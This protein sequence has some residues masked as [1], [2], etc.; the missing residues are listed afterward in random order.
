MPNHVSL[1]AAAGLLVRSR[2]I[3]VVGVSGAGKSTLSQNIVA[4]LGLRYVSL[5]RDV[6]WLPGWEVRP[7]DAQRRLHDGFVAEEN[8]VID[9]TTI[10]LMDTR[11]SRA[12]LLI[13]LRVPRRIAL[14]GVLRRVLSSYGQTRPDMAPGCPEQF[15]D[16]EFLN[17]IWTFEKRQCPRLFSAID[18]HAPDLPVVTLTS[19]ADAARLLA[20][21]NE[22]SP[23]R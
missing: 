3:A 10:G 18:Q 22:E 20:M 7:R 11:L 12:D 15:P 9:G 5:D 19:R 2:R 6:R 14:T 1:D 8:W 16:R 23:R 13:W 4:R 21:L 17:W